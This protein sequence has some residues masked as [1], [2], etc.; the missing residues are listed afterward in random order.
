MF[1]AASL[2]FNV[3]QYGVIQGQRSSSMSPKAATQTETTGHHVER[4]RNQNTVEANKRFDQL[5]K[6]LEN[7][8]RLND[9]MVKPS[10]Y[11]GNIS[12][13]A[14]SSVKPAAVH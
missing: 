6:E 1:L 7:L 4:K 3:W 9:Q 14:D 10:P 12:R 2:F 11:P 8:S 5:Y 13:T